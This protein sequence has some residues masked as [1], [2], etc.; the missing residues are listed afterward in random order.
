MNVTK[1]LS[2]CALLLCLMACGALAET[3]YTI[4]GP[5]G[6]DYTCTDYDGEL[7]EDV[8]AI[9]A[10]VLREGDE[11][12]CGT[13]G[14]GSPLKKQDVWWDQ[15]LLAV[16]REGRVLLLCALNSTQERWD[17]W[18]ETDSFIPGGSAFD[19]TFLPS[20]RGEGWYLAAAPSILC[21]DEIWRMVFR[22]S[23]RGYLNLSAYERRSGDT[24]EIVQNYDVLMMAYTIR[25]GV[26]RE[27][28]KYK[29]STPMRLAAWDMESFPRDGAQ[30]QQYAETHQPRHSESQAFL[31]GANL[32][33]KPTSKSGLIG[34]YS[35]RAEV[36]GS[37]MG[38]VEPWYHVRVGD[39]EGWVTANYCLNGSQYDIRYYA[40][41]AV[42]VNPARA[43]REIE[44]RKSPNG[45]VFARLL[46]GAMMHVITETDGWLHV[47]VPQDGELGPIADWDGV[48]GYVRS[49]EVVRG[50]T[51]ADLRWK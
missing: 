9:L 42:S 14:Q 3:V 29:C 47:I 15:I 4:E 8:R 33:E 51:L 25:D 40:M 5:F 21:D 11:V 26:Y 6:N 24:R 34:V 30:L 39:T 7:P 18:I 35:A 13:R 23:N 28:G 2:V 37:Q 32:R 17:V 10:P 22:Q 44:L 20:E 46:P 27:Q 31:C 12:L 19:I 38:T 43:D 49:S 1:A 36:L 16:R 45:E 50:V 41:G 48:Y